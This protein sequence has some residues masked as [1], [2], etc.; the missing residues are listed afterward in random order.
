MG[1]NLDIHFKTY[2][3][4]LL[5]NIF[6]LVISAITFISGVTGMKNHNSSQLYNFSVILF[7]SIGIILSCLGIGKIFRELKQN[8]DLQND[9]LKLQNKK[10]QLEIKILEKQL[11]KTH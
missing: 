4:E 5:K 8:E 1:I 6:F 7:G 11:N 2:C 3:M 10:L 9:N